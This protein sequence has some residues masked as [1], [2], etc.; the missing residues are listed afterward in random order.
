VR[1]GGVVK[2]RRECR[3]GRKELLN[4]G[5]GRTRCKEGVEPMKLRERR[6]KA[7]EGQQSVGSR[8]GH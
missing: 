7:K 4:S 5:D 6:W 3:G 8:W 2:G 1:C